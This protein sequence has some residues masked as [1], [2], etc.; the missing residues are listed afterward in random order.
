MKRLALISTLFFLSATLAAQAEPP[1]TY[2]VTF[3]GTWSKATHP[4][5][6][7]FLAH[8]SGLIGATHN[9][10]Y[11]IFVENGT[12]T[13]G[14]EHLCEMGKH[15]PL[16][17]EIS[18]AV[19]AGTAG[20]LFEA[21]DPIRPVPGK[22]S[23]TFVIDEKHPMV[24]LVAMIAPSPDWFAGVS[25]VKLLENGQWVKEKKLTLYA[26]DGGT[27]DGTSYRSLDKDVR[28]KGKVQMN[29]SEH[30]LKDAQPNPVGSVT[31]VK[32]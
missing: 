8:F 20:V 23:V 30:F 3:D 29:R 5:D 7:P 22:A 1:A 13:D 4:K 2:T 12:A 19:Q 18:H 17:A 15:T 31:F 9:E 6:F 16:D 24:S 21:K 11:A 28:P 10:D 25:N 14:L 32:Q 27:D 26:W